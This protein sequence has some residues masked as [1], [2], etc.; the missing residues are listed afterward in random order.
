III[1]THSCSAVGGGEGRYVCLV[2]IVPDRVTEFI[3]VTVLKAAQTPG[4]FI[5]SKHTVRIPSFPADSF[6]CHC[7]INPSPLRHTELSLPVTALTHTLSA[8]NLGPVLKSLWMIRI[9]L[10]LSPH[11][12]VTLLFPSDRDSFLCAVFGSSVS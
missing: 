8:H 2:I 3:R 5:P 11:V 7:Y 9:W 10:L 6:I 4:V 12:C 1:I